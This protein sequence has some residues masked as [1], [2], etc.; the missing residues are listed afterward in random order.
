MSRVDL[1]FD[2]EPLVVLD[3]QD[4]VF[5]FRNA[6]SFYEREEA[7]EARARQTYEGLERLDF[8]RRAAGGFQAPF[9]TFPATWS[10][11]A[12]DESSL[13]GGPPRAR[14]M[15]VA[16]G[17]F[18]AIGL[19]LLQ[20]RDF[21]WDDATANGSPMAVITD[22]MA[23][24]LWPGQAAL[25]RTLYLSSGR[26]LE[27]VGVVAR[28]RVDNLRDPM[29]SQIYTPGLWVTQSIVVRTTGDTGAATPII[30]QHLE[31]EA[32]W[33]SISVAE[34]LSE[35][36][37]R[38]AAE[39][40]FVATVV[41]SLAAAGVLLTCSGLFALAAFVA[42][43][44]RRD[45]AIRLALGARRI[46]IVRLALLET[47]GFMVLGLIAGALGSVWA[48]HLL[49]GVLFE[50]APTDPVVPALAASLISVVCL[51][52]AAAPAMS[53]GRSGSGTLLRG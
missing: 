2:D 32:P 33:L 8:V 1:G 17:Y 5:E 14:N 26:T 41:T 40:R 31:A 18:D 15:I 37:D 16:P 39:L 35:A 30:R 52:A 47:G 7:L 19:R 44:R 50:V 25:G 38:E 51:A 43:T 36:V 27:V 45:T 46:A 4:Q 28:S 3:V 9:G 48:T 53:A 21:T 12:A 20:G 22:D 29:G 49:D 6:E 23:A 13:A 11:Y 24:T 42:R 10:Y 34:P